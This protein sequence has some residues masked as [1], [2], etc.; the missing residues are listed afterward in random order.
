VD[1]VHPGAATPSHA[2]LPIC[3]GRSDGGDGRSSL[4]GT[5][6]ISAMGWVREMV[7]ARWIMATGIGTD[8]AEEAPEVAMSQRGGRDE[9]SSMASAAAANEPSTPT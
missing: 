4:M 8:L 5:G 9:P 6:M 7:W 1:P 2:S 3:D